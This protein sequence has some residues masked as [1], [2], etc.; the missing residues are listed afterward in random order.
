MHAAFIFATAIRK[1]AKHWKMLACRYLSLPEVNDLQCPLSC[2]PR[3][4]HV[5]QLYVE[6][7]KLDPGVA[8]I[9]GLQDLRQHKSLEHY[10]PNETLS[11]MS[12][13]KTCSALSAIAIPLLRFVCDAMNP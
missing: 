6:S 9:W 2:S 3:F 13:F 5:T 7:H 12:G 10:M 8:H 11:C 1:M 4:G